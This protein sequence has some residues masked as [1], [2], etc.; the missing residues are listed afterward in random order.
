M[1]S[2]WCVNHDLM[3]GSTP[4]GYMATGA[5]VAIVIVNLAVLAIVMYV[6]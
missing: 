1:F 2:M 4:I 6:E 3:V 5:L